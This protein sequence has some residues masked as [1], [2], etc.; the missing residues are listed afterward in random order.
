[1]DRTR[2]QL[3]EMMEIGSLFSHP[4]FGSGKHLVAYAKR[5]EEEAQN[6]LQNTSA[7]SCAW[8][9]GGAGLGQMIIKDL[10]G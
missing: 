10:R 8:G 9:G 5:R 3:E 7:P 2:G 1:M 4:L 6:A